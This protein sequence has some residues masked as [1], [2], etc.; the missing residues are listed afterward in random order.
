MPDETPDSDY[1]PPAS[2]EKSAAFHTEE[3][4]S[5]PEVSPEMPSETEEA[6]LEQMA[7][8]LDASLLLQAT[9]RALINFFFFFFRLT[10]IPGP[11]LFPLTVQLLD[12]FPCRVEFIQ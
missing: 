11:P 2:T 3:A 9:S 12:P 10:V 6:L 4:R 5:T 1:P 7:N 8:D